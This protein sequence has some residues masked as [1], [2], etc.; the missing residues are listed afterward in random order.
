MSEEK[1]PTIYINVNLFKVNLSMMIAC[2]LLS[3]F[4]DQ[5]EYIRF[6]YQSLVTLLVYNNLIFIYVVYKNLKGTL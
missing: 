2:V 1:E 4:K 5:Y 3:Y 6:V